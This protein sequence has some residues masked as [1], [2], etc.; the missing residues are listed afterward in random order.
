MLSSQRLLPLALQRQHCL[1]SENLI[2]IS[3]LS[4]LD[5][6][7][8]FQPLPNSAS[9]DAIVAELRRGKTQRDAIDLMDPGS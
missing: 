3:L 8:E 5:F 1:K 2:A 4:A 9:Q 7:T 6:S